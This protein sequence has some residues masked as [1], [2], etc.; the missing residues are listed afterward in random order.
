[1]LSEFLRLF[2]I[3]R[4]NICKLCHSIGSFSVSTTMPINSNA[5]TVFIQV[6]CQTELYLGKVFKRQILELQTQ[7]WSKSKIVALHSSLMNVMTEWVFCLLFSSSGLSELPLLYLF[8]IT[9]HFTIVKR[10]IRMKSVHCV[11]HMK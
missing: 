2:Y 7:N 6:E 8:P 9:S 3:D 10:T 11:L 1:M 4:R 5:T